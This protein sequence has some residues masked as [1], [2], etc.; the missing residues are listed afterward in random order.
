MMFSKKAL[1]FITIVIAQQPF[2]HASQLAMPQLQA[3]FWSVLSGTKMY[4]ETNIRR[5][6]A[7]TAVTAVAGLG[8]YFLYHSLAAKNAS[9]RMRA[10]VDPYYRN[11]LNKEL[12]STVTLLGADDI[13]AFIE[14]KVQKLINGGAD[15]RYAG[16]GLTV[17]GMLAIC[18]YPIAVEIMDL[19]LKKAP[20]VE[21]ATNEKGSS[22]YTPLIHAVM[23]GSLD[24]IRLLAS[25]SL[26]DQNVQDS[27]GR[28]ALFWA[29][30]LCLG[31]KTD[32]E[33]THD[34]EV[35]KALLAISGIK[36]IPKNDGETALQCARHA[37][38]DHITGMLELHLAQ[39][40]G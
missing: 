20:G 33:V 10:M 36:D 4:L 29:V 13:L 31:V 5:Y 21:I 34:T 2:M 26:I 27:E 12:F 23:A 6:A 37:R 17:L 8:A 19:L 22:G 38:L 24:M 28:T 7:L 40:G 30:A 9:S 3:G 35:I 18:Q 39:H 11:K 25:S 16:K 1:L 14:A 32:E 15:V